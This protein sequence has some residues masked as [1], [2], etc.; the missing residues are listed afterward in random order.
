MLAKLPGREQKGQNLFHPCLCLWLVWNITGQCH[1]RR[2]LFVGRNAVSICPVMCLHL[3]LEHGGEALLIFLNAP[4]RNK[5][6]VRRVVAVKRVQS[7][8][9]T[10]EKNTMVW[11]TISPKTR[12]SSPEQ[13]ESSARC[14]W[15]EQNGSGHWLWLTE[16]AA[17]LLYEVNLSISDWR[18][19]LNGL[20][21]LWLDL[22]RQT[23]EV[24]C[25]R[26]RGKKHEQHGKKRRLVIDC[27]RAG[28]RTDARPNLNIP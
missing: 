17:W 22:T 15:R 21:A 9:S 7:A 6:M 23:L 1:S 2:V 8:F 16:C 11:R 20:I 27:W 18:Q 4:G 19:I 14:K 10:A 12:G 5:R 24:K 13:R 25:D 3:H 26:G 28:I